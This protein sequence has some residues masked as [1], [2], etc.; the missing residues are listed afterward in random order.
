MVDGHAYTVSGVEATRTETKAGT[1]TVNMTGTPTVLDEKNN[2]VTS[3]FEVTPA[4]GTLV[5][6][7][8]SVKLASA[9]DTK[10]Y[11]G[12]PLT[13]DKVT[14]SGDD[15]APGEGATYN[16]TGSRLLVGSSANSFTYDLN[17]GTLAENYD[18]S[19]SFGTLT[20]TNRDAKYEIKVT[21]QDAEELYDGTEKTAEGFKTLEFTVDGNKYTVE[22][23]TSSVSATDAGEY[24]TVISGTAVVKDASGNDVTDQFAVSTEAG[25]LK[26]KK[27]AVTLTSGSAKHTY[28]GKELTNKDVTVSGDGFANGEGATYDVTGSRTTVGSS[29]NTFTYT[30]NDGTNGSNYDITQIFGTLTVTNR[31]A[32]YQITLTPNS[33]S[34]VYDGAE[35]SVGGFVITTAIVEDEK[36]EVSGLTAVA[37]GTDAGTYGVSVTGTPVVTDAKGNNV[38]DQFSVVTEDATLTI[39]PRPVVIKSLDESAEYDGK[40]HTGSGKVEIGGKGFVG[41]DGVTITP[42]ASRTLVGVTPNSFDWAFNEGTNGDNYDV[43]TEYGLLSIV[44]RDAAYEI[45]LTAN[46][47]TVEY[48]GKEHSVDGFEKTEFEVDGGNYA[49]D[50]VEASASGTETGVYETEISGLANVKDAEGNDVTDQFAVSYKNGSLTITGNNAGAVVPAGGN[51]GN[52]GGNGGNGGNG[53]G[54]GGQAGDGNDLVIETIPDSAVVTSAPAGYWA[55]FNLI[56][57]VLT[58]IGG[59]YMLLRRSRKEDDD[60]ENDGDENAKAAAYRANSEEDQDSK[61]KRILAVIASVLL[62]IISVIVFIVTEDM[63]NTMAIFDKYSI[64]M[65]VLMIASVVSIVLGR[66]HKE[67]EEDEQ[68]QYSGN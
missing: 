60:S 19:T 20:V 42:T 33:D 24:E 21:G 52:N 15:F 45:T 22:G 5:I 17:Q 1:Y 55:M 37:T 61:K 31:D 26:I 8:R 54:N 10:P 9:S 41:E 65:A 47:D 14:V 58:V 32:K 48:D 39:T 44:N 13:N 67:N 43:A 68:Q 16:V 56:M 30:L 38:T 63:T 12:K 6:N 11:D 49:V 62:A 7:K 66:K 3:Q 51:G 59:I 25:T 23:L 64:L 36:Y 50:G 53:A 46:S 35:H 29:E 34:V 18:I 2:D 57:T 27:R 4:Q 40:P 28:T